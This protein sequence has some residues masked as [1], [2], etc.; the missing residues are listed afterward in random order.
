[1]REVSD[2]DD[3]AIEVIQHAILEKSASAEADV[4]ATLRDT[5]LPKVI[6]GNI[7]I[8]DAERFVQKVGS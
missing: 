2:K 6:S 4:L 1:V 7:Q 3:R 8:K 5:L